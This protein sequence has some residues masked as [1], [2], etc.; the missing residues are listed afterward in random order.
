MATTSSS[1]WR[2]NRFEADDCVAIYSSERFGGAHSS[3]VESATA[4][5]GRIVKEMILLQR[6]TT[7]EKSW[8]I[9]RFCAA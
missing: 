5:W 9:A 6:N 3:G 2:N 8:S 1:G 7:F 4:N